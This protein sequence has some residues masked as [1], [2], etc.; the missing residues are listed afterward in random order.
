MP[1]YV[2][3]LILAVV[4]III[5]MN[6]IIRKRQFGITV[7]FLSFS[8]IV[9]VG[10]FIVMVIGNCYYYVPEVLEVRYYDN[11][12]GA[13]VSNLF[14]IPVLGMVVAVYQL[15]LRWLVLFAMILM[16]V[17]EL[18]EWLNIY[19]TNWWRREYTFISVM[20][21]LFLSKFWL[22]SLKLGNKWI[23]FLSLWMQG[24]GGAGTVMY[25]MSVLSIRH[26]EY[27]FFENVYRDNIF[28]SA[29]MGMM[30]GLIF[31]VGVM[32][33]QKLRW[34]LL[35][36]ALVFGIDL[37]LYY[38]GVLVIEIPF[39]IYTIVYLVLA[40]LLLCWTHYANSFITKIENCF[41]F[42]KQ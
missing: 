40:T 10:E 12:L 36:P 33:F 4:S 15:R 1:N 24:W 39:L 25:I 29:L 41:E 22:R 19:Y 3:Y 11:V 35:A 32:F 23:R 16:G 14:V 38:I 20:I 6:L 18:F 5:L 27:G 2:P 34:R 26:Y 21:F 42:K 7:L 13:I 8:G 9:Y 37:P 31:C 17:G 28:I 30:K